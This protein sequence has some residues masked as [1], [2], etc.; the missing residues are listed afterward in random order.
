MRRILFPPIQSF[1][2]LFVTLFLISSC[3][4]LIKCYVH[5]PKALLFLTHW[6]FMWKWVCV[7]ILFKLYEGRICSFSD[8]KL[9]AKFVFI[10]IILAFFL[11][12]Y[13]EPNPIHQGISYWNYSFCNMKYTVRFY[14]FP[15]V[16]PCIFW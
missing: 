16:F 13:F 8:Y 5:W 15:F 6:H 3:G 7:Q 2:S 9:T 11:P 1:Q 4:F 12:D 14:I 10:Y